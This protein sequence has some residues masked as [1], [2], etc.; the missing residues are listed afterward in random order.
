MVSPGLHLTLIHCLLACQPTPPSN[1]YLLFPGSD[2]LLRQLHSHSL[3][4]IPCDHPPARTSSPIPVQ[5]A[6]QG[7]YFILV[8]TGYL[9]PKDSQITQPAGF[10]KTAFGWTAI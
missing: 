3:K 7:L 9:I 4:S 6:Y 1:S 8:Y 10:P 2:D 5:L